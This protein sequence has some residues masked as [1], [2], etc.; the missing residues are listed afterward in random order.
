MQIIKHAMFPLFK[1]E[2]EKSFIV[3]SVQHVFFKNYFFT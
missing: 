1:L 3:F 2:Y